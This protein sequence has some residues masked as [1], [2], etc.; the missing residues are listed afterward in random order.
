MREFVLYID[1]GECGV[2]KK[3]YDIWAGK[4]YDKKSGSKYKFATY[5]VKNGEFMGFYDSFISDLD[6]N[7]AKTDKFMQEICEFEVL[8]NNQFKEKFQGT[9]IDALNYIKANFKGK[10]VK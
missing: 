3:G 6:I 7:L 5:C 2:Y 1:E 10:N 8:I 9:F 4:D